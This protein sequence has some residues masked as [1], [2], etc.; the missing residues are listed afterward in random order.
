MRTDEATYEGDDGPV[1]V[2]VVALGRPVFDALVEA[3][4]PVNDRDLWFQD[5]FAPALIVASVNEW[6]DTHGTAHRG[7]G[8]DL[9]LDWW[10]CWPP[11]AAVD[12]FTR[13]VNLN[14]GSIEWARRRLDRDQRLAAEVA[15]SVNHGIPHSTFLGWSERDQDLA[16]AHEVRVAD[17]CPGCG[18]P[19]A[20]MDDPGAFTVISDACVHCEQM[21]QVE[22]AIPSDQ[23]HRYHHHLRRVVRE[24]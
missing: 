13:C 9:A 6:T 2:R 16:L 10:D 12:L 18:C 19:A 20:D 5:S 23:S 21:R 7:V 24:A 1:T 15:Y 8:A 4:P 22:A 3:H 17:R 14:I 11:D